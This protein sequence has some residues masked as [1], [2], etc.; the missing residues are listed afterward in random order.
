MSGTYEVN[1]ADV[2]CG[3]VQ[4]AN[5]TVYIINT[6]LMPPVPLTSA[7]TPQAAAGEPAR[8]NHG[9]FGDTPMIRT[10]R[11][12]TVPAITE[13]PAAASRPV[14]SGRTSGQARPG[15]S[16]VD[17]GGGVAEPAAGGGVQP[18]GGANVGRGQAGQPWT[19]RRT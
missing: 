11:G 9:P 10:G 4:T 6:V 14:H 3:N 19:Q 15:P 2:V 8:V 17:E 5:A 16:G 1:S 12:P 13:Q 7:P 18:P